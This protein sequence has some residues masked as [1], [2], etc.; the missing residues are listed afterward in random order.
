MEDW[1]LVQTVNQKQS[2]F[3]LAGNEEAG[4][5]SSR[6]ITSESQVNWN[7]PMA[8]SEL[9]PFKAWA[10]TMFDDASFRRRVGDANDRKSEA[11]LC[12]MITT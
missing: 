9:T 3:L 2:L 6:F 12:C 11:E 4:V 10:K 7:P 5:L 8:T 1:V